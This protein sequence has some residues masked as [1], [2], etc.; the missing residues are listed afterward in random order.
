MI[1]VRITVHHPGGTFEVEEERRITADNVD[2]VCRDIVSVTHIA[3]LRAIAAVD[4]TRGA[5][6]EH[7][8][9]G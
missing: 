2:G 4:P 1:N 6:H 5:A 8:S 7:P 9:L 3:K